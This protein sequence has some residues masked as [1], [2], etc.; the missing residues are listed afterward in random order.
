MRA[1][2][3]REYRSFLLD[4]SDYY[5][6]LTLRIC[7]SFNAIFRSK[8]KQADGSALGIGVAACAARLRELVRI[9]DTQNQNSA[10]SSRNP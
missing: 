5:V 9:G 6:I 4:V 7:G 1:M 10:M 2:P 3:P 8:R